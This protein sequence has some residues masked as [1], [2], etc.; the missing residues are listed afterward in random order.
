MVEFPTPIWGLK[1]YACIHGANEASIGAHQDV[2]WG[3][4]NTRTDTFEVSF[5]KV[6]TF[7]SGKVIEKAFGWGAIKVLPGQTVYGGN[8]TG[9]ADLTDIFFPEDCDCPK[10]SKRIKYLDIRDLVI[11]NLGELRRKQE[12]EERIRVANNQAEREKAKKEEPDRVEDGNKTEKEREEAEEKSE[13]E[14]K[15]E[16]GD[17]SK[18]SKSYSPPPP[19]ANQIR[20]GELRNQ[21]VQRQAQGTAYIA[22]WSTA[23]VGLLFLKFND[24]EGSYFRGGG[25]HIRG[26]FGVGLFNVS[27]MVAHEYTT[28]DYDVYYNGWFD[29][30]VHE[31][32]EDSTSNNITTLGFSFSAA[33]DLF[34][35]RNFI[36]GMEGKYSAGFWFGGL[37][38]A[39]VTSSTTQTIGQWSLTGKA[40]IGT[41]SVKL[42]AGYGLERTEAAGST[43]IAIDQYLGSTDPGVS[44]Q[45]F[46]D[47]TTEVTLFDVEYLKPSIGLRF[48]S[49]DKPFQV[50]LEYHQVSPRGDYYGERLKRDGGS[51]MFGVS[52]SITRVNRMRFEISYSQLKNRWWDQDPASCWMVS[53]TKQLDYFSKKYSKK[54]IQYIR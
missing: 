8:F 6:Y 32:R 50:D 49:T 34:N 11:V 38:D 53:L 18:G 40:A 51:D 28:T 22:G 47:E 24:G 21:A 2:S 20:M 30:H 25:F 15:K 13:K 14:E 42:L 52:L 44:V 26:N 43:T 45:D 31:E 37:G 5:T 48:S 10:E 23:T 3:I 7:R 29:H 12:Q 1:I 27:N 19:T 33:M 4:K 41:A 35:S 16:D 36:I 54:G 17:E 46:L 39:T 9:D